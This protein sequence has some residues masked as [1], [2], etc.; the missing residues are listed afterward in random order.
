MFWTF[1]KTFSLGALPL[2]VQNRNGILDRMKM[3]GVTHFKLQVVHWITRTLFIILQNILILLTAILFLGGEFSVYTF[4]T[5]LCVITLQSLCGFSFGILLFGVLRKS[6]P[7]ILTLVVC[8]L[9]VSSISGKAFCVTI[10]SKC[11]LVFV[12]LQRFSIHLLWLV[13][14]V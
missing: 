3:I 4:F 6:V 8:E 7:V 2:C 9:I 14:G 5:G 12:Y 13:T 10:F 11:S 1:A